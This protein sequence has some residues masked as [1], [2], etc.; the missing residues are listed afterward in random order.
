MNTLV[1]LK[2]FQFAYQSA[3]KPVLTSGNAIL[4][5][6]R[7]GIC[8][9][10]L[11]AFEGAQPF[12]NYPRILGHELAA[13]LVDADDADGFSVGEAV[14]VLP[15]LNCG[16]C[17]ACRAGRTNCCVRLE[18]LGIHIDG[19][20]VEYLSVP[21]RLLVHGDGLSYE[22]LASVEPLAIG[23]HSI[24]RVGVQPGETVLVV[25][26]GPIGLGTIAF[27][28]VAG[29]TVIAMDINASRLDFCRTRLGVAHTI[30]ANAP[31]VAEQL[32]AL[33]NGDMPTVVMDAT[34]SLRAIETSFDYL[35]HGG[36]YG[37][38]GLQRGNVSFSHPTF[39]KRELTLMSSRNATRADFEQ[40]MLTIKRSQ[41]DPSAYI[42]HQV[43]FGEVQ[44]EF[45]NWLNPANGVIKAMARLD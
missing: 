9:T 38:V 21:S 3:E 1:C 22:E 4:R 34:G 39:H 8:G 13:D 17:M 24:R 15:Y 14:T 40:V 5:I 28:Q 41:V 7:V 45:T 32:A 29:A 2:P 10:D 16:S 27:A 44:A 23:A 43:D 18:V 11:H 37:L 6:R 12:F 26:A 33:T 25:G 19:G 20:M 35:A 30:Q 42:T 31:D 36:R